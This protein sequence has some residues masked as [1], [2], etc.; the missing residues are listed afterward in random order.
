M[1]IKYGKITKTTS[2]NDPLTDKSVIKSDITNYRHGEPY[3]ITK[4]EVRFKVK[5][6]NEE[7]AEYVRFRKENK[8]KSEFRIEPNRNGEG[9]YV[10]KVWEE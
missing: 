10:I 8:A 3:Y 7:L 1:S 4:Y 2:I 5:D 9:Y 6:Y